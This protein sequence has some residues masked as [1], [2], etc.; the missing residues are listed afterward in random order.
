MNNI[1]FIIILLNISL[2]SCRQQKEAGLETGHLTDFVEAFLTKSEK[3]EMYTLSGGDNTMIISA[4]KGG[5]IIS[6]MN[7]GKEIMLSSEMHDVNYG[8][9]L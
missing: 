8:A 6:F 1:H 2:Y 7:K 5:R 9:T 4:S 3:E